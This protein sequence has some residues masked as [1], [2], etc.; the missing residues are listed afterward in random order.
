[1]DARSKISIRTALRAGD[2]GHIVFLHGTLYAAERGWDHT[3]DA[4]VA[5]DK[6]KPDER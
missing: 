5:A 1:M 4:Y 6:K 3:V 2:P